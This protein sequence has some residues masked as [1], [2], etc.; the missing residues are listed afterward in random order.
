MPFFAKMPG[1]K[2]PPLRTL[3]NWLLA[4]SISPVPKLDHWPGL[5]T[6][7]WN[8]PGCFLPMIFLL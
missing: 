5:V 1:R 6:E 3:P 2:F 7:K 8:W 4:Q